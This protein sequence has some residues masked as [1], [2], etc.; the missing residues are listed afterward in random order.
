M[1]H[2]KLCYIL[3]VAAVAALLIG[4][5]SVMAAVHTGNVADAIEGTWRSAQGQIR[6]V[7]DNV[8]FPALTLILAVL[9]FVKLGSCY[10]E[11]KKH[12]QLELT[13]PIILFVSTIFV[14]LG[15][16]FVWRIIG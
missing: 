2:K 5:F 6:T 4:A 9:F 1:K 13:A 14:L 7:V 15:P 3:T 12:G 8:V 16:T 11:Y 10:F